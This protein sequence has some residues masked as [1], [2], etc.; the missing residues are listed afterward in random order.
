MNN[1]LFWSKKRLF[2]LPV[3]PISLYG[4]KIAF[5][6]DSFAHWTKAIAME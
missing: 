4:L 2:G 6:I 1:K 5:I 3:L